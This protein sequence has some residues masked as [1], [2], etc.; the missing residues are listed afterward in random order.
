MIQQVSVKLENRPDTL[1]KLLD[2][3]ARE[4]ISLRA[5]TIAEV[6]TFGIMR[7]LV[8]DADK[9]VAVLKAA[10]FPGVRKA[11]MLALRVADE[12]GITLKAFNVLGKA[13]INVEYSYAFTMQGA[14]HAIILLR[15]DDNEKAAKLLTQAGMALAKEEDLF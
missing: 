7:M 10:G 8:Q 11:E 4:E 12:T 9:T 15:V 13:G 2:C 14:S 3:L 5:Y 6:E 1:V